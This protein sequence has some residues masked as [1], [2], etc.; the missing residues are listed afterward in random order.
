VTVHSSASEKQLVQAG[1]G[2]KTQVPQS[3]QRWT[4]S[5]MDFVVSKENSE[6]KPSRIG[7]FYYAAIA[8]IFILAVV[9]SQTN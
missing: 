1:C 6:L 7:V 2:M 5:W 4:R 3:A 8:F 9:I